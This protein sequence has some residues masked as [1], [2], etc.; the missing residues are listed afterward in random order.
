M[1]AAAYL[2]LALPSL[3]RVA[4]EELGRACRLIE[5]REFDKADDFADREGVPRLEVVWRE[6]MHGQGRDSWSKKRKG[7]P[8]DKE[9]ESEEEERIFWEGE[10]CEIEE[11]AVSHEGPSCSHNQREEESPVLSQSDL[12][13]HLRNVKGVTCDCLDSLFGLC[14]GITSMSVNIDTCEDTSVGSQGSLLAAGIQRWSGQL[15][16]LSLLVPGPLVDFL[17]ALQV[18]GSSLISLTLEGVK[19]SSRTPLMEVLRACPRLRELHI[20]AEP[21]GTELVEDQQDNRDVP[22]LPNLRSLTL[23]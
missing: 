19:T 22:E 1:V 12:I 8:D 3:E 4:M 17:H 7:A 9:D 15:Q 16:S 10:G 5:R 21:P 18:I 23:R 13:L 20:S 6:R 11:D 14:P 2:L